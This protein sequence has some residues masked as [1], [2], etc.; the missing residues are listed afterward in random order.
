MDL[1]ALYWWPNM[2]AEIAN[3]VSKFL[4]HSKVK[5]EYQRPQGLL[6]KP[7]IPEWKWEQIAMDFVTKLPKTTIGYD[8][9]LGSC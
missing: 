8:T 9:I 5:A 3:Y 6:Q 1:K 7:E 2:K 4:T